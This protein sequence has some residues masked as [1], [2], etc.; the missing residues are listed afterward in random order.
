MKKHILQIRPILIFL[1]ILSTLDAFSQMSTDEKEVRAAIQKMEDAYNAHDFS[2]SGKYDL[3]T[4]DAY[5]IN[6][7]GMYWKNK[8]EIIKAVTVLGEIRLKHESVKYIIKQIQFLAPSV[9]LVVVYGDGRVV[10]DYNFPD[11]SKG[12]TKGD[13]NK[14]MYSFTLTKKD[15]GW[16]IASMQITSI[17]ANAASQNPIK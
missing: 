10:E 17:D 2:F 11:G 16:K 8:S 12:G 13:I 4:S 6:P 1:I 15:T 5:F 7:V 9:A 14:A 3:L